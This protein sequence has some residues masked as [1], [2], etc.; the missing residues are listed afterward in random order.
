MNRMQRRAA[1]KKGVTDKDLKV[2][3]QHENK[4]ATEHAVSCYSVAVA[5]TLYNKLHFG[6]KKLLIT[7]KQIE[8]LFEAVTE[9]YLTFDDMKQVLY[10]EIGLD[11]V[12][13]KPVK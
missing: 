2:L 8:D 6:K 9:D 10:D 1:A 7:M 13:G 4:K 5:Y 12:D 3:A 11:F